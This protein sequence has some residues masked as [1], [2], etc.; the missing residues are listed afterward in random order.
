MIPEALVKSHE[1]AKKTVEPVIRDISGP[2]ASAYQPAVP[3][4]G[5]RSGVSLQ[6]VLAA[7]P[8]DSGAQ[9]TQRKPNNTGLPD[10]LKSNM[11]S[12]SGMDMSSTKVHRNSPKPES[13][14]AHA[15]T[16]G[17]NI[18]LAPGQDKHLP[19]EA[20]H[21]V[22]Q[23]QGRVKATGSVNGLPLNDSKS[24]ESEADRMGSKAA[25]MS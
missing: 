9:I 21:V 4:E 10:K 17:S 14:G 25:N 12:L 16:Q 6:R 18:Y 15:Y 8:N 19:H 24:L 22:Q 5:N 1:L 7:I 11:E 20:W 2:S 3:M 13:V 23:A